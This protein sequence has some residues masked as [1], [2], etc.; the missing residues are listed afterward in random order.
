MNA[1]IIS[2]VLLLVAAVSTSALPGDELTLSQVAKEAKVYLR[3]SAEFPLSS[4]IEV[5]FTD[6][7]GHVRNHKTGTYKYDFH[8]YNV[9][10][11]IGKLNLD[12]SWRTVLSGNTLKRA[13]IATSIAP[14][15]LGALLD[16]K[17]E[18]RT[19]LT[20]SQG[21]S[22][23]LI[24]ARIKP[25]ADCGLFK[26]ENES[27]ASRPM[28]GSYE[29]QL[30]KDDFVLKHFAFE[31]SRLPAPADMD[32]LGPA[33]ISHYHSETEFQKV[34]LPGDPKPFLVPKQTTVTVETDKG[35]LVMSGE[36]ALKESKKK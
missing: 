21:A 26:W 12:G 36:F 13:A 22:P 34:F 24:A 16:P 8:G 7:A 27:Y 35:K 19:N 23:D 1:K 28:C 6:L 31:A 33:T 11:N 9:R 10:S 3:D 2:S 20:M 18:K 25:I 4:K 14:I 29:L 5:T 30:A 32:V 17:M 15:L